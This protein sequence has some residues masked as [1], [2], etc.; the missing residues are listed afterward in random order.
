MTLTHVMCSERT[1]VSMF[2]G[3]EGC[4]EYYVLTRSKMEDQ[5]EVSLAN[6]L[7]DYRRVMERF[8]ISPESLVFCRFVLS[9][10]E[11]MKHALRASELFALCSERAYSIIGQPP[12]FQG[13][14]IY[15]LAYHVEGARSIANLPS[16]IISGDGVKNT[17]HVV[18]RNSEMFFS[19]ALH[20]GN[21]LD[22]EVQTY[23]VFADYVGLLRQHGMTLLDN[24]VRT[25]IYCRDIDNHYAGMVRSRKAV[26]Q[27][28]GLV[29]DTHYIASTG[30]EAKGVAPHVLV[31]MDALAYKGLAPEQIVHLEA[32][33]NM[34]RTDAYG[35]TFERGTKLRF[36]DRAHYHI[37]GT[38][39]IDTKGDVLFL[40][41]VKRQTARALDNIE[42]LLK[43]HGAGLRD[44]AY[45]IVYL[46][47][48]SE[49]HKVQDAFRQKIPEDVPTLFVEGAVCRPTW[50]VEIEG[51]AITAEK[52]PFPDFL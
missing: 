7:R 13:G 28:E 34:G 6:V 15:F 4:A 3:A 12:G 50:L 31:T 51:V 52:S 48:P 38:A 5:F 2:R 25:W 40:A 45:F 47:N 14:G 30:I 17:A 27:R 24:C 8:G 1:M 39:S 22:S 18:G 11:N 29:P 21:K 16:P 10:I 33:D 37:S 36:G 41:D 9:D 42:A 35:V 44:M 23:E 43:P 20:G 26:F 19:G 46:R 49:L 32:P